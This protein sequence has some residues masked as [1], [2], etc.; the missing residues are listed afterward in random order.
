MLASLLFSAMIT[1]PKTDWLL[2]P[3]SFKATVKAS[4]SEIVLSNGLIARTIKLVQDAATVSLRNLMT[5]EEMLRAVKPEAVLTLNGKVYP[6]GGLIGQKNLAFLLPEWLEELKPNASGFHYVGH[7]VGKPVKRMDWKQVRHHVPATW[8]PKGAA[9]TLD[10]ESS[11]FP[12]L[13]VAVHYE[14]YDGVP[15]IQKWFSVSNQGLVK[16]N[17][18][19]FI[20]ENIGFAETDSVVDSTPTWRV[21]NVTTYSDY[22]FGGMAETSSNKTTYWVP[23]PNYKTQVNYELKTPCDLEIRPPVGPDFTIEPKKGFESFRAFILFHDSMDRERKGLATKALYRTVAPW[24]T[25]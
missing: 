12:G 23:D 19:K 3:S 20:C 13:E 2:A 11:E 6:V 10:F 15:A 7:S 14:I 1:S 17:L 21:P 16:V 25:E 18:D 4:S 5:G 22:A 24:I 8:P 9:L